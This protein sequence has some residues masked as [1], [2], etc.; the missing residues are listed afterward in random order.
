[1]NIAGLEWLAI[2]WCRP[3]QPQQQQQRFHLA[4]D[5]ALWPRPMCGARTTKRIG[6]VAGIVRWTEV[7]RMV[8]AR[9]VL[10]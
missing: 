4:C 10:R 1:V 8:I 3:P 5:P 6:A 2:L 9:S 7:Q